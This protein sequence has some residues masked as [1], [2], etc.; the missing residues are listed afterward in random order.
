MKKL[1]AIAG[2]AAAAAGAYY[3]YYSKNAKK[4]RAKVADWMDSA[5]KEIVAEVKRL[6][7]E[8]L[9]QENYERIVDAVSE[10]YRR[11]RNIEATE[12]ERFTGALGSAWQEF[13]KEYKRNRKRSFRKV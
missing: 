3:L 11:L 2:L 12:V 1:G 13:R 5:K 9:T 10:K 6:K 8:T 4:N 7:E